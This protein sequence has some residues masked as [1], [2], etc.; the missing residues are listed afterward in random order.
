MIF[1]FYVFLSDVWRHGVGGYP[2][3][4]DTVFEAHLWGDKKTGFWE[5]AGRMNGGRMILSDVEAVDAD[6]ADTTLGKHEVD[7]HVVAVF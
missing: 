7:I 2:D 5:E 4:V 1:C 6:A 3:C